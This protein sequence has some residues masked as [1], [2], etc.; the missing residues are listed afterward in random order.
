MAKLAC[1]T[2]LWL[3]EELAADEKGGI[4][5]MVRRLSFQKGEF[6][7]M[8]GQPASAVFVVTAGRVKLF[9]VSEDGKEIILGFLTLHDLFGE[10]IL[11]ADNLRTF[12]AQAVE[13]TR[14]CACFKSDF[15]RLVAENST[16]SQKVIRTLGQK[17]SR[18]AEH[19]ADVAVYGTQ[20]RVA[21]TLARL[22]REYGEPVKLG[23]RLNFRLTHEELGAMV[24]ASRVMVTNVLK[25]LEYAGVVSSD[26]NGHKF[27]VSDRLLADTEIIAEAPVIPRAPPCQCFAEDKDS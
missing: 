9:K 7:F 4:E 1:M 21:R 15:E 16:I 14:I 3:F 6:L 23:R 13:P 18:M 25:S 2:D 17:L 27:V 26:E 12:S 19:L 20:E 24:G 5:N 8:E 10:E 11:F 22:A